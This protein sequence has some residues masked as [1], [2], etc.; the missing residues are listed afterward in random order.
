MLRI[1]VVGLGLSLVLFAVLFV[2]ASLNVVQFGPCGPDMVGL[3]LLGVIL[4][5]GSVG[6][7]LLLFGSI[8]VAV[9]KLRTDYSSLPPS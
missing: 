9:R 8:A 1:G 6:A 3:C 7:V 5:S 4:L 2:G